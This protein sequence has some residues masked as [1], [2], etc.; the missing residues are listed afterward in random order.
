MRE[1]FGNLVGFWLD[2][3]GAVPGV[4][5]YDITEAYSGRFVEFSQAFCSALAFDLETLEEHATFVAHL[6]KVAQNGRQVRTWLE[7]LQVPE[8]K[9]RIRR[10]TDPNVI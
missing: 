10:L 7:S 8:F 4:S 9:K 1:L 2:H 5:Y 3:A 6:R